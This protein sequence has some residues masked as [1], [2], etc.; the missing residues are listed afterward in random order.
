[1]RSTAC[2]EN[3][4][5]EYSSVPRITD[6]DCRDRNAF[7]HLHDRKKRVFTLKRADRNRNADDR[8]LRVRG[9]HPRKVG[10]AAGARNNHAEAVLAR[11]FGKFLDFMRRAMRGEDS[12]LKRNTEL[13]ECFGRA[14]HDGK[15]SSASHG[16][17][18][19]Y[20]FLH[21]FCDP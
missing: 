10:C 21:K 9:D 18:D 3:L 17:S 6:R 16:D 14:L 4:R 11:V 19:L 2:A 12:D 1:M 7:R 8:K 5:G 15:I 13:V 20:F